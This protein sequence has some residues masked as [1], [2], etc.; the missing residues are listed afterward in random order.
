MKL[1]KIISYANKASELRFVAMVRSLR[2]TGC[3]LP[4][5]VIPYDD[6]K[7]ILPDNC[8]WW[9]MDEVTALINQYGLHPMKRKFQCLLTSNYHFVDAD[10]V[11]LSNPEL[12][13]KNLDGFISSCGH[14]NNPEHTFVPSTLKLF[15]EKSTTWQKSVFNSGQFACDIALYDFKTLKTAIQNPLHKEALDSHDQISINLFVFLSNIKVTN[16]TLPP[17]NRES[18]WAGDYSDHDFRHYWINESKK[19]YLVH[20]AGYKMAIDKPID[21]LFLNYLTTTEKEEL[22]IQLRVLKKNKSVNFFLRIYRFI[23]RLSKRPR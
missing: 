10:I 20:W 1:E 23:K 4:V 2:A 18:S 19:P 16:V 7:F 5:W 8:L 3:D 13:L 21:Q 15:K 14:W 11:F 17:Y 12:A 22:L 9:E 6:D